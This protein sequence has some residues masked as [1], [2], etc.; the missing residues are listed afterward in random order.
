MVNSRRVR[1]ERTTFLT[2]SGKSS[3]FA[4][5]PPRKTLNNLCIAEQIPG[6]AAAQGGSKQQCRP[7]YKITVRSAN[8][9]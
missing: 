3:S 9:L 6:T 8:I 7:V 4:G 2:N 1:R 5:L